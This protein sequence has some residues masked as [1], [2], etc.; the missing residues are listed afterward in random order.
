MLLVIV[1][2]DENDKNETQFLQ[3]LESLIIKHDE[4]KL[5]YGY[6]VKNEK[7]YKKFVP[8]HTDEAHMVKPKQEEG[9]YH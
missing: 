9:H 2:E 3:I 5:R 1:R 4:E 8:A 7:S 6:Y